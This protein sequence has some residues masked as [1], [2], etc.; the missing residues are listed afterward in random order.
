ME[1]PMLSSVEYVDFPIHAAEKRNAMQD[2]GKRNLVPFVVNGRKF[3]PGTVKIVALSCRRNDNYALRL[4]LSDSEASKP[5][6]GGFIN[7]SE[8]SEQN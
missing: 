1:S 6:N 8:F 4:Q 7:Y 5:L 3:L 2:I